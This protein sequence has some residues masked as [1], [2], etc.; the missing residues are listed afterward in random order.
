MRVKPDDELAK[1][2][3]SNFSTESCA[4]AVMDAVK[5]LLESVGV[6]LVWSFRNIDT[7]KTVDKTKM[8]KSIGKLS[9][10]MG[11]IMLG[12]KVNPMKSLVNPYDLIRQQKEKNNE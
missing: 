1:K 4:T 2:L 9:T 6:S 3:R 12:G 8:V 5:E 10:A 7:D 11:A